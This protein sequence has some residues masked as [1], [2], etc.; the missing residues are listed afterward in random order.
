MNQQDQRLDFLAVFYK[1]LEDNELEVQIA[2]LRSLRSCCK[3]IT[4]D[5]IEKE[6]IPRFN[7]YFLKPLATAHPSTQHLNGANQMPI[8]VNGPSDV[9]LK[10]QALAE[11]LMYIGSSMNAEAVKRSLLPLFENLLNSNH[12]NVRVKLFENYNK[13]VIVFGNTALLD[14]I[15]REFYKFVADSN[16]RI[17]NEGFR[18]I[19]NFGKKFV[20]VVFDDSE[21]ITKIHEGLRDRVSWG[22]YRVKKMGF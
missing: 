15:K 21:M 11:N 14:V 2:A 7:E 18:M 9:V 12:P 16:W 19:E 3:Y 17:R 4:S 8:N 20:D 1:Y 13:L 6:L 10:N 22:I 5:H